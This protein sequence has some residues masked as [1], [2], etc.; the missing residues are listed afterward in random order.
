VSTLSRRFTEELD[1]VRP[2][3]AL[4]YRTPAEEFACLEAAAGLV[5]PIT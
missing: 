4:E 2:H 5:Y 3:Y 1:H